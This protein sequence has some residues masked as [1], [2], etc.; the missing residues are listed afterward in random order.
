MIRRSEPE[1]PAGLMM[2]LILIGV[3]VGL[4]WRELYDAAMFFAHWLSG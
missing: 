3:A 1:I 4:F 2:K